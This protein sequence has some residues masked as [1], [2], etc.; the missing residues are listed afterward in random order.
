MKCSG[1]NVT[2]EVKVIYIGYS[3]LK[4]TS[5]KLSENG[6]LSLASKLLWRFNAIPKTVLLVH[7]TNLGKSFLKFIWNHK[8]PRILQVVLNN[9]DKAR[10]IPIPDRRGTKA[11]E[12]LPRWSLGCWF[13]GLLGEHLWLGQEENQHSWC[14]FKVEHRQLIFLSSCQHPSSG[15]GGET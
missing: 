2:K 1:F 9:K 6:K 8:W 4:R 13:T 3:A 12:I 15:P 5:E 7:P 10:R 11:P 14:T